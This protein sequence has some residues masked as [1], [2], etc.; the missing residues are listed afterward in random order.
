MRKDNSPS[1]E[2]SLIQQQLYY[3][4]FFWLGWEDVSEWF[5]AEKGSLQLG[6]REGGNSW[7]DVRT[8]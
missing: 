6:E 2:I 8:K 7:M 4:G 3:K 5:V 1:H